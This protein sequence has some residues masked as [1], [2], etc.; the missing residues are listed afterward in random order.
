[1]G[2]TNERGVI[3]TVDCRNDDDNVVQ[4]STGNDKRFGQ[5]ELDHEMMMLVTMMGDDSL[6]NQDISEKN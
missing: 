1:M 5:S 6:A 4:D 3:M 2:T